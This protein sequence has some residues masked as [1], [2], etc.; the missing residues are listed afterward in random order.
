MAHPKLET[1]QLKVTLAAITIDLLERLMREGNLLKRG[2]GELGSSW[3]KGREW[4]SLIH[5]IFTAIHRRKR[6]PRERSCW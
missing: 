3:G 1:E 5:P 6:A 4:N 2:C